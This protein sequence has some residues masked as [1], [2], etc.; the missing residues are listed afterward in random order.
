MNLGLHF[1]VNHRIAVNII[2]LVSCC[3]TI[4]HTPKPAYAIVTPI[5]PEIKTADKLLLK[6]FL[7]S[8]FLAIIAYWIELKAP[9]SNVNDRTL[10]TCTNRG[11]SK[12]VA[13]NG[14]DKKRIV[15]SM[16]ET[17]KFK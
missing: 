5:I 11:I 16:R 9:K 6:S 1:T 3:V 7:K 12:K 17:S 14:A 4:A 15:Y 2:W 8:I 10:N 13:I